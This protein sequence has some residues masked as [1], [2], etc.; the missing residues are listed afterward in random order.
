M[1]S[2]PVRRIAV[3]VG[4][5]IA[6]AAAFAASGG[7]RGTG[8]ALAQTLPTPTATPLQVPTGPVKIGRAHV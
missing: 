8:P 4:F 5:G 3:V 1:S 7:L 6:G 2:G